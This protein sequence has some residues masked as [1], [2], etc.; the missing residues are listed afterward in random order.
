MDAD[1]SARKNAQKYFGIKDPD[2]YEFEGNV[3]L[4]VNIFFVVNH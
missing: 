2:F 1:H 4:F 3:T